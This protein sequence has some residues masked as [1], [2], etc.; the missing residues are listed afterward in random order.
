MLHLSEVKE[1]LFRASH[2]L[3]DWEYK[4]LQGTDWEILKEG[5]M[6]I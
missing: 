2:I 3:E 5:G 1:Q 4:E 6:E